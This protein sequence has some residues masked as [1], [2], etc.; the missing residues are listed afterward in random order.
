MAKPKNLHVMIPDKL[1]PPFVE[2]VHR[3]FDPD[4]NRILIVGKNNKDYGFRPNHRVEFIDSKFKILRVLSAMYEADR[5]ILH[6][7]WNENV[8]RLLF[9]QPWLLAKCYW[10][11]WG[12]DF[13]NPGSQ[14]AMR[15]RLIRNMGNLVTYLK[16]D[17]ELV[18]TWYGAG[19]TYRE[20]LTYPSN[21][22][23]E[24]PVPVVAEDRVNVQI[25]NSADPSNNH[26]E[27]LDRLAQFK[28]VDF[29]IYC[30]LSYGDPGYALEVANQ[31]RDLFGDRFVAIREFLPLDKYIELLGRIDIA[32]FAHRRQQAMGNIIPLLGLGK[33]VF[34]RRDMTPWAVFE[35]LGIRAYD[36]EA[37]DLERIDNQTRQRNQERVKD[38]FSE[39]TLVEQLRRIL[40]ETHR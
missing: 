31:G 27:M 33:K 35:D 40:N 36:L 21:L 19:G 37:L 22:Y 6:G 7:L 23:K 28:A 18:R 34:L 32:I 1:L 25:G 26:F 38:Y 17:C 20:C 5:I 10:V 16:G 12:G 11:M 2:L 30:P 9:Y 29:F 3:N 24:L 13:Y 4:L 14:S 8:D 15:K 39:T